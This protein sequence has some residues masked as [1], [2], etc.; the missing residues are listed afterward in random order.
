MTDPELERKV[1]LIKELFPAGDDEPRFIFTLE[2]LK[3]FGDVYHRECL[4]KEKEE[5]E[6]DPYDDYGGYSCPDC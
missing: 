1:E 6:Y 5:Q 3:E 2:Q 4:K